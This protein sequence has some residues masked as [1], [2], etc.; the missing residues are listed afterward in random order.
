MSSRHD[1]ARVLA[2]FV[3]NWDRLADEVPRIR[4][5]ASDEEPGKRPTGSPS[6]VCVELRP[7]T[8][9][10]DREELAAEMTSGGAH[11]R[12]LSR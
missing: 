7:V 10:N 11:R 2:T 12:T 3:Q 9:R 1:T 6:R 8:A 4:A 5:V